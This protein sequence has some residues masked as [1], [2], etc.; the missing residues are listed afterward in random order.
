MCNV[1]NLTEAQ[2]VRS[3]EETLEY[4][5]LKMLEATE[6]YKDEMNPPDLL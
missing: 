4:M 6:Y 1:G 2:N 5:K 3:K